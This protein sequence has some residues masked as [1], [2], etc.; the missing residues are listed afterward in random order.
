MPAAAIAA[1]SF[2]LRSRSS[3]MVACEQAKCS[4]SKTNRDHWRSHLSGDCCIAL[5]I[6]FH[7]FLR[8]V[9]TVADMASPVNEK[10]SKGNV[11][12]GMVVEI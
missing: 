3:L 12:I 10:K 6:A 2:S 8:L 7:K 4:A 9:P 11:R 5:P 1:A